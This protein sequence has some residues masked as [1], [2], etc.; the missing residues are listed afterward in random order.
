M[1][2][3][4]NVENIFINILFSFKKKGDG[5]VAKENKLIIFYIF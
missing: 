5:E 1:L 4:E 2:K 3:N